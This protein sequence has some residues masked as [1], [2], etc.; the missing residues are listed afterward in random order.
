MSQIGV[1]SVG[2]RSRARNK[3]SFSSLCMFDSVNVGAEPLGDTLAFGCGHVQS[4]FGAPPEHVL[5]V[6][7]PLVGDQILEFAFV[8]A[9]AEAF[10][11][12]G[13]VLGIADDVARYG[14]M[15]P[16]YAAHPG[17]GQAR[18]LLFQVFE[19]ST[20]IEIAKIPARQ[21]FEAGPGFRRADPFFEFF[22]RVLGE[23]P[24]GRDLA[25][26]YRQEWRRVLL[27]A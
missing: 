7:R 17:P 27:F 10:A 3:V 16:Q 15:A 18:E 8:E 9:A 14:A 23:P 12:A 20:E 1:Y 26:E 19:Q 25:A 2:S 24:V 22:E 13:F 6:R 5:G 21:G 11:Q 4:A